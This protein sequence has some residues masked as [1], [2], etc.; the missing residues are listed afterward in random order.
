M[1]GGKGANQAAAAAAAGAAVV[2][3]GVVGGDGRRCT[4]HLDALGIDVS[5]VV[6]RPSELTG[7]ATVVV[8]AAG[9]NTIIV[10]SNANSLVTSEAL[11]ELDISSSDVVSVQLEVP[12]VI[13]ESVMRD[14]RAAGAMVALNPS[15]WNESVRP[16]LELAD[17]VVVNEIEAGFIG[18]GVA[19]ERLCVTAGSRGAQWDGVQE[20]AP[21]VRVVDTT[22]AGDAFTG[23]L[24]AR[25]GSGVDKRSALAAAVRAA[26]NSCAF[27]GAQRWAVN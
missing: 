12:L 17:L 6:E 14:A 7:S 5:Q 19:P 2:M 20:V 10:A 16:L 1:P 11:G 26:S 24:V 13:V 27:E 22:G 9:R 8:D 18:D 4:A 15:P 23:A 3:V 25:L 21:A